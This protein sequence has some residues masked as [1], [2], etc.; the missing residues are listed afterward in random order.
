MSEMDKH[1]F[2][3]DSRTFD[4]T[5]FRYPYF[6]GMRVYVLDDPLETFPKSKLKLRKLKYI[7][8]TIKSTFIAFAIFLL[9]ILIKNTFNL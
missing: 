5:K 7:H 6:V 9:Y 1:L 3:A 2:P 4:W 8:Y